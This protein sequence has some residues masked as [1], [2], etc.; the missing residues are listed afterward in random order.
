[1]SNEQNTPLQPE[2]EAMLPNAAEIFME[3][4]MTEVF[5]EYRTTIRE[6]CIDLDTNVFSSRL[7]NHWEKEGLISDLRPSGKGWRKHSLIERFWLEIIAELRKFGYPLERIKRLRDNLAGEETDSVSSMPH[8][9]VFFVFAAY[10]KEPCYLLVYPDDD[11]VLAI[12]DEH[13]LLRG[14]YDTASFI[15]INLNW[16][17]QRIFPDRDYS[18]KFNPE[19]LLTPGEVAVLDLVN[20]ENVESIN[21]KIKNGKVDYVEATETLSPD[22]RLTD[23]IKE[24]EYQNVAIKV[25]GGKTVALKRTIKK[26]L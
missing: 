17:V 2:E 12:L 24:D 9:E 5:E 13:K 11:A 3:Y 23:V 8:L 15:C 26:K 10:F 19:I 21:I 22:A 20:K 18:A 6:K 14:F 1:M 4:Y 25:A 16:L 7:I